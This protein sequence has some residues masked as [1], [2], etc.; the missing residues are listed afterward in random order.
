[1]ENGAGNSGLMLFGL[2]GSERSLRGVAFFFVVFYIVR[3]G[4]VAIDRSAVQAGGMRGLLHNP[5]NRRI[6]TRKS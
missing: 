3:V 4:G 5:A 2:D 1:M 6:Y